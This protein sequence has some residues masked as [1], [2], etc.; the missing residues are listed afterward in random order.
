MFSYTPPGVDDIEYAGAKTPDNKTSGITQVKFVKLDA[1]A[2][3]PVRGSPKAAGWDIKSIV[4]IVVPAGEHVIVSTGLAV[5]AP[6]DTYAR[7]APRSSMSCK[8]ISVEAGVIDEDYTGEVG[9]ILRNFGKVDY[10]VNADDKIAQMIFEKI[11]PVKMVE[12]T[13]LD[14][15]DRGSGGFGSTGV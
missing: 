11:Q 1:K 7:L 8:G 4:T 13:T 6:P 12:V 15:T 5:Q 2:H 14:A 9:V 10:Q 3:E